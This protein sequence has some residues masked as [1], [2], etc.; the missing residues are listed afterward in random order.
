MEEKK[1]LD[2]KMRKQ[3][4]EKIRQEQEMR[5][6]IDRELTGDD[7]LSLAFKK[8][9]P[10]GDLCFL[11]FAE[12]VHS[13]AILVGQLVHNM[14]DRQHEWEGVAKILVITKILDWW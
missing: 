9:V 11:S 10:N 2:D 1:D 4:E 7:I 6:E 5:E 14:V 13:L 8:H 12:G 3:Q